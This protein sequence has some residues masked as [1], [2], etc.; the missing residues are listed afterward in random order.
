M[1]RY[2]SFPQKDPFLPEEDPIYPFDEDFIP[3]EEN[4]PTV[5]NDDA[6]LMED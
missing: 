5:K 1:E 3:D 4:F 2:D 6:R